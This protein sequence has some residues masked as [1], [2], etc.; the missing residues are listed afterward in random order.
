MSD[1]NRIG[2]IIDLE[3]FHLNPRRGKPGEFL[4]RELGWCDWRGCGH[5]S[6][7]YAHSSRYPDLP[8]RDRRTVRY[9]TQKV[10]GLPFLPTPEEQARPAF[11]MTQDIK[12]LYKEYCTP[13]RPLVG[14]KGGT[15]ERD[16]LETLGI[17]SV[18]LERFGCPKYDDMSR[19]TTVKSCGHHEKPLVH[20]CPQVEC[21]HFVQSMQKMNGLSWDTNYVNL[22]R[23]QPL[24]RQDPFYL[25]INVNTK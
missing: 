25:L 9:V 1:L 3:G 23:L 22:E 10:H 6:H 5:G 13:E 2:M 12:E 21:Y 7:H 18:N 14:Y 8:L 24:C 17:P 16:T 20:H 15:I 4:P 11:Q 19:L